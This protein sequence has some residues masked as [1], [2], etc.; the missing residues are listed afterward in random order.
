MRDV[1]NPD[2]TVS[3]RSSGNPWLLVFV[4]YNNIEVEDMMILVSFV[5]S[6]KTTNISDHQ[7]THATI[8]IFA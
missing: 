2:Y 3:W 5:W 6:M 4:D 8:D 7:L 1:S